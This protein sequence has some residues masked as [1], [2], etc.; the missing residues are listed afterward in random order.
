M[1]LLEGDLATSIY[2]GFKGKLLTGV[3]RKRDI[4]DSG[5][6]DSRGDPELGVPVDHPMEGFSENYDDAFRARA[7]IPITDFK[8]NVF[9]KS[10]PGVTL[11]KDDIG[12]FTRNGVQEWFQLRR[13]TKD[14]AGAL[15]TC[16][17]FEIPGPS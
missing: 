1:S 8:V 11:G 7:G 3:I 6:L 17:A 5:A 4:A 14:P 12:Y 15:W 2:N 16:Q 9:G 10:L 13:V